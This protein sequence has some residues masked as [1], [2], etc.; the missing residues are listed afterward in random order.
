ME[1]DPRGKYR[2]GPKTTMC[3]RLDFRSRHLGPV[4]SDREEILRQT[5]YA[6]LSDLIDAAVPAGIRLDEK[7]DL[8]A[9]RTD[10][11]ALSWLK[12]ILSPDKI[13]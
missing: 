7:L 12:S 3:A 9:A 10:E 2:A 5:G 8:P 13:L 6:R 11:D 4:G 1:R